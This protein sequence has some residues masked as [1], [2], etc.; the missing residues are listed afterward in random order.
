[1]TKP[2]W[3]FTCVRPSGLSLACG[4]T[5]A[6]RSWAFLWA[7]HLAV[8]GGARQGENRYQTRAWGC[9][10][11]T[12]FLTTS[13]SSNATS[14]RT[15]PVNPGAT[16]VGRLAI[17]QSFPELQQRDQRQS[18]RRRGGLALLGEQIDKVGIVEEHAQLIID[19]HNRIAIRE[20]RACNTG[21]LLGDAIDDLG[22]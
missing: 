12:S 15:L 17:G 20:N 11:Y 8:T 5:M 10:C 6:G 18:N 19:L 7:S 3:E 2:H 22:L 13:H 21:G 16:G 4:A 14:C 9:C 1:M